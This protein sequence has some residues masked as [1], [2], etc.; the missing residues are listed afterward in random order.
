MGTCT[1]LNLL[2][3]GWWVWSDYCVFTNGIGT[4]VACNMLLKSRKSGWVLCFFP[5]ASI[6]NKIPT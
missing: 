2:F 5:L 4:Y 6:A 3:P 1:R